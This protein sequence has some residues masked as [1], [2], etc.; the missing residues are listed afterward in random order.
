[1]LN[2]ASLVDKIERAHSDH[3]YCECG[4]E[5]ITAYRDGAMWLDCQVVGEPVE[6]RLLRLWNEIT[7]PGHVH[8]QIVEVP[9]PG[10]LAA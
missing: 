10:R 2:E 5:T 7:G 1:M 9:H 6:N 8:E 4:R 3:P